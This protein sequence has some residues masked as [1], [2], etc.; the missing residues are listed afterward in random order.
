MYCTT[1]FFE[2]RIY[3]CL[4][5][6]LLVSLLFQ[7]FPWTRPGSSSFSQEWE[8]WDETLVSWRRGKWSCRHYHRRTLVRRLH[9]LKRRG[10]A[11]LCRLGL[12]AMLL[13]RSGWAQ[14][15]PLSWAV[16]SLPLVD[17]WLCV[18]PLYWP[19]VLK[20]RA[21]SYLVQ[22]THQLHR[23][24]LMALFSAGLAPQGNAGGLWVMGGCIKMADGAWARGEIMADGTWRLEMEGHFIFTWKPCDFFEGAHLARLDASVAHAPKHPQASVPAPGVAGRM[25]WHPSG[26][27]QPLAEVCT[28]KR[29]AETEG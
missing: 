19:R 28:S 5:L 3:G 2:K 10:M 7:A 27:D 24:A 11:L 18:W 14:R 17:A 1:L 4:S 8:V 26:V 15:Q 23:L 29:I 16:L 6:L 9:F 12:M 25:V 13:V 20:V 22:G 21:Y